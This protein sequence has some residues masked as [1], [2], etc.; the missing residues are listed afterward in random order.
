MKRL[1][2]V[3]GLAVLLWLVAVLMG[4]QLIQALRDAALPTGLPY[5]QVI[6]NCVM[7]GRLIDASVGYF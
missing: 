2:W 5:G 3:F 7:V 1:I 6:L 4:A